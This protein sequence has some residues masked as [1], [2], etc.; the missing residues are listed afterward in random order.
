MKDIDIFASEL[1]EEAK[2]FLEKA[3]E[4]ENEVGKKAF[5]HAALLLGISSLEAHLNAVSD[6]MAE[7]PDLGILEL[8]ILLEKGYFFEKGRFRLSNKL[9]MYNLID[10]I[11]FIVNHFKLPG[12]GLDTS[13]DWWG[14]LNQGIDLR[15]SLVHPKEKYII[16]YQQ[17]EHAFEGILG[18]LDAI[19]MALYEQ[20][21]P[22][23]GRR[24]D[25]SMEF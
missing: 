1:F 21:F 20:H 10:R 11:E 4:T 25:S 13:A 14:K 18:T 15:N 17:V 9:K 22:A 8:S 12:K 5:L 16:T 2:R 24:L 7:R 3:Q 19:Y 6:E 23:L